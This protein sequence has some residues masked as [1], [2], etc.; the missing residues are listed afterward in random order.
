[1]IEIGRGTTPPITVKFNVPASTLDALFLTITQQDETIIEKDLTDAEI[2][3]NNAVFHLTQEETLLLEAGEDAVALMQVRWV[4]DGR[5]D[6]TNIIEVS[7]SDILKEG[8]IG[9]G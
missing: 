8:V 1:M 9:G 4:I 7:I 2:D 6:K 5:A 3:G